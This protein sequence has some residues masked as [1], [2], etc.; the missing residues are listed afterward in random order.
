MAQMLEEVEAERKQAPSCAAPWPWWLKATPASGLDDNETAASVYG[1]IDV[2]HAA[3]DVKQL[4]LDDKAQEEAKKAW[5]A[6]LDADKSKWDERRQQ[7]QTIA[8]DQLKAEQRAW[9]DGM[10][11]VDK[12]SMSERLALVRELHEDGSISPEELA[13][14][15]RDMLPAEAETSAAARAAQEAAKEYAAAIERE[16]Q[17]AEAAQK[18][19]EAA[20]ALTTELDLAEEKV[21]MLREVQLDV[22]F[23]RDELAQ[24]EKEVEVMEME[25]KVKEIEQKAIEATTFKPENGSL[26]ENPVEAMEEE[27]E[28]METLEE[29]EEELAPEVPTIDLEVPCFITKPG[30]TFEVAEEIEEEEAEEE[31]EEASQVE[32]AA[33]KVKAPMVAESPERTETIRKLRKMMFLFEDSDRVTLALR[34]AGVPGNAAKARAELQSAAKAAG[35][36]ASLRSVVIIKKLLNL[37]TSNSPIAPLASE[38]ELREMLLLFEESER[39][40]AA[41]RR[42]IPRRELQSMAKEAGIKANQK[43]ATIVEQLLSRM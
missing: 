34:A 36:K 17:A 38:E 2:S 29:E 15:T 42:T 31:V 25:E 30:C 12:M 28:T 37:K 4:L 26:C 7:L 10:T 32:M 21:R 13:E 8:E 41:I 14:M 33:E 3:Q 39:I 16:R 11:A 19:A 27:H 43:S 22:N 40:D 23:A 6:R 9:L 35:I 18:A 5:I 1:D 20:L 24:A